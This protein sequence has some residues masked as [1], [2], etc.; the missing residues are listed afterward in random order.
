[1][2][3]TNETPKISVKRKNVQVLTDFCLEN[4]I[5][6][7]MKLKDKSGDEWEME[8]NLTNVMTAIQLGMFL[9]ENK[10]E[11]AIA[12]DSNRPSNQKA[13]AKKDEKQHSIIPSEFEQSTAIV[14]ENTLNLL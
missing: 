10:I 11:L 8:L 14:E 2:N 3:T 12:N 1:M 4:K 7:G 9:K 5:E 6:F 13:N